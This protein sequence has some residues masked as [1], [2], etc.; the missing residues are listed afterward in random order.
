[1]ALLQAKRGRRL[2]LPREEVFDEPTRELEP[3][4]PEAEGEQ[5]VPELRVG[6]GQLPR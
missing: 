2:L 4:R 3:T 1:V 6:V 5:Q